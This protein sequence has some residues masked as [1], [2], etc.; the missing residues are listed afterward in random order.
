VSGKK[1]ICP[2]KKPRSTK[3]KMFSSGTDVRE[4]PEGEVADPGLSGNTGVAME[5]L[6]I[7]VLMVY[8]T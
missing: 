3:P 2:I 1:D 8:I 7:V 4:E 6:V 5:V